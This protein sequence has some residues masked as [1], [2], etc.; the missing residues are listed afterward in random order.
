MM[1]GLHWKGSALLLC[2]QRQGGCGNIQRSAVSGEFRANIH[3]GGSAS[4]V[5]II[6][7][8]RKLATTTSK[9]LLARYLV[10]LPFDLFIKKIIDQ[11]VVHIL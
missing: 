4:V 9:A 7:E 1:V 5:K 6:P 10:S 3:Q 2:H 11:Y 8:E